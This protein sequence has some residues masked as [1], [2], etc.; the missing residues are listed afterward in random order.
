MYKY[1][2]V[3][4][5]PYL[6]YKEICPIIVD[7]GGLNEPELTPY[8]ANDTLF[9]LD[10]HPLQVNYGSWESVEKDGL[11]W[12]Y[13]MFFIFTNKNYET[14]SY[15]IKKMEM[16]TT[17]YRKDME[18]FGFHWRKEE[19]S[20]LGPLPDWYTQNTTTTYKQ[21]V[22]AGNY[23]NYPCPEDMKFSIYL[24]IEMN[25]DGNIT[26]HGFDYHYNLTMT[27]SWITFIG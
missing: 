17:E 27:K 21:A 1:L 13:F 12:T 25:E 6:Y 24:E 26:T 4:E 3:N 14:I 16:Y 23:F 18:E 8:I 19:T 10:S 2:T 20:T 22:I 7:Q 5:I 15:K 9:V 11:A